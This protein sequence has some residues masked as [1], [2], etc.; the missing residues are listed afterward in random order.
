MYVAHY[1]ECTKYLFMFFI[2]LMHILIYIFTYIESH[3]HS[4]ALVLYLLLHNGLLIVVL[5]ALVPWTNSA[6]SF[7]IETV[8]Y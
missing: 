5:A 2:W 7:V 1:R 6:V 4:A 8:V 3:L